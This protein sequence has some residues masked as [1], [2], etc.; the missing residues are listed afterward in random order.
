MEMCKII[1]YKDTPLTEHIIYTTDAY[2]VCT[3]EIKLNILAAVP[4]Y[5][6]GLR[7]LIFLDGYQMP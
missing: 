6:S 5:I 7:M 2:E 4:I 3:V 1:E